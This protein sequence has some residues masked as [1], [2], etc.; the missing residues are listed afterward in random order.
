[1][2]FVSA[3][4][5]SGVL[6]RVFTPPGKASLGQWALEHAV[7]ALDQ[8]AS[9]F[10]IEYPLPKAD[11]VALPE[12]AM[13]AM[14]NWGLVTYRETK[15]LSASGASP[16]QRQAVAETVTYETAHMHTHTRT[17][18]LIHMHTWAIHE[19]AT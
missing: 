1:M 8:F 6:C 5:Q 15:L 3:T 12:F 18:T 10:G 16:A 13:G 9:R 11:L 2:D 19:V 7:L 14:E 4:S 17:C